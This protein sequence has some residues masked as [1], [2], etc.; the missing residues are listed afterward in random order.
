MTAPENNDEQ[1]EITLEQTE[2]L[3]EAAA[4]RGLQASMDLPRGRLKKLQD[5]AQ[6]RGYRASNK[7][8]SSVGLRQRFRAARPVRPP[9]GEQGAPVQELQYEM[10]L[11]TLEKPN[12]QDQAAIAT[13]TVTAGQNTEQYDL[14]LEAPGGNFAQ[15][16]E[17]KV[18]NDQVVPAQSWWTAARSCVTRSCT[19]VC[20]GSLV[21]CSGTWA[22]YLICV[23]A[24]CGGCWV[25]CAACATCNCKWW[26]RWATGCCRQ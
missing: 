4:G 24:A 1:V 17:F 16:Q 11:R 15:A 5:E 19:S 20:V 2:I 22:A 26:C 25:K 21:T 10:S 7:P 3:D 18:E 23:A 12:S 8:R 6:K 14:L 13:V 9:A